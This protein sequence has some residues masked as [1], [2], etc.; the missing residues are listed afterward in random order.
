MRDVVNGL[1]VRKGSVLLAKRAPQRA[2]YPRLWSFPGGHVEENE[3]LSDA[4]VRELREEIGITPTTYT[5]IGVITD[6]STPASDPITY[7]M[8]CIVAWEGGEPT[9]LGDEHSELAWMPFEAA[10]SVPDLALQDYRALLNKL[11]FSTVCSPP[12]AR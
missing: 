4:L 12:R 8:Y 5:C 3:T 1:L 11:S 2:T 9:M 6:P 10:A 7:H